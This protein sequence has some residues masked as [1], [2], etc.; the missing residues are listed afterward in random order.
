MLISS[1]TICGL[2]IGDLPPSSR[3]KVVNKCL[4][5]LS[6]EEILYMSYNKKPNKDLCK[7]CI[8]IEINTKI[9]D[10]QVALKI[11]EN[12]SAGMSTTKVSKLLNFPERKVS[13]FLKKEGFLSGGVRVHFHCSLCL[14]TLDIPNSR[15]IC[16]KCIS[17]RET[18]YK[19]NVTIEQYFNLN[20]KQG[21]LCRICN[22]DNGSKRLAVDHCHQTGRVRGLLCGKCNSGLG[23]F[24][25][26]IEIISK[27][28]NYIEK[29]KNS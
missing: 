19:I 21:G 17:I 2:D 28:I 23:F 4:Q 5:C 18:T 15:S 14:N 22:K 8:M 10:E 6:E 25:D 11:I 27:A 9:L 29:F 26:N 3:K 13:D 16:K 1:K 7:K 20:N 24:K 12:Y